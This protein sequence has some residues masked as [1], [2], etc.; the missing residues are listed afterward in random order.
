[1][2]KRELPLPDHLQR[3]GLPL[4]YFLFVLKISRLLFLFCL[5]ASFLILYILE[6]EYESLINKT[7]IHIT[8]RI[9]PKNCLNKFNND[10]CRS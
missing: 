3:G 1:M 2:T 7:S 4:F 5:K 9:F 8:A 6:N 10:T